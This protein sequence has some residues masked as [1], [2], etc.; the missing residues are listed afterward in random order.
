[1]TTLAEPAAS[2]SGH[3]SPGP[4][5]GLLNGFDLRISGEP[6]AL[7]LNAQRL[8]AFLALH[9]RLLLRTHVAGSL[10]ADTPDC[11]ASA[12]LRSAVWRIERLGHRLLDASR[13]H[14]QLSPSVGVD[15]AEAADV[16]RFLTGPVEQTA[17]LPPNLHLAFS[18]GDLLPDW[19]DEADWLLMER[20]RFHQLRL[21]ALEHLCELLIANGR[22]VE[23]VDAGLAAVT[24]DPLRESA[25]RA[26]ISAYLA[27][28]NT[29]EAIRQYDAFR[30]LLAEEMGT[31][32]TQLME[33][34]MADAW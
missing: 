19:Y 21:H 2:T 17:D 1:M 33:N 26:V 13:T 6:V 18:A 8:L 10:W 27:E 29:V 9:R 28:G 12:S 34:L 24:A 22:I 25:H 14:L 32:P 4:W 31:V 20:T 16:A 15:I 7:P 11:R 30:H 23:A 3:D 5:I